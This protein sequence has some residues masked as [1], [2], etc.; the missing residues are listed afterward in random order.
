M[1]SFAFHFLAIS[2]VV[3]LLRF[4]LAVEKVRF[5]AENTAIWE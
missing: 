5:K 1:A 2:L 4:S 3:L